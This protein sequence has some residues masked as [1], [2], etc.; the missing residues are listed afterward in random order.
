MDCTDEVWVAGKEE[1]A[2]A[3]PRM[4]PT[5]SGSLGMGGLWGL[6]LFSQKLGC[7]WQSAMIWGNCRDIRFSAIRKTPISRKKADATFY[8]FMPLES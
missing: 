6:G 2:M 5:H 4:E 3:P 7:W 1:A 8:K